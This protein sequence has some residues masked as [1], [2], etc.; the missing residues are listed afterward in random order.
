MIKT[1]GKHLINIKKIVIFA[2][3]DVVKGDF[4]KVYFVLM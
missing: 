3:R 2:S 4:E 1:I